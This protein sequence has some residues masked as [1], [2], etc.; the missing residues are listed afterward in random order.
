M[1]VSETE[2]LEHKRSEKII[3]F[4]LYYSAYFFFLQNLLI[5]A[6]KDDNQISGKKYSIGTS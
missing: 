4:S 3:I 1:E 6:V 5:I 2:D